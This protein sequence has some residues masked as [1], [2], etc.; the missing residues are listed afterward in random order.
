MTYEATLY[1]PETEAP[2]KAWVYV[3]APDPSIGEFSS[4]I[5]WEVEGLSE[6]EFDRLQEQLQIQID[7][8]I[9]RE[10]TRVSD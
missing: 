2:L 6:E 9:T 7:D 1:H 10:I 8:F 3:H 4:W 5:D